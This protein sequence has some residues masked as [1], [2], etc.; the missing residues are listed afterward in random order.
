[1][2]TGSDINVFFTRVYAVASKTIHSKIGEFGAHIGYQFNNWT[3]YPLYGPMAA[4]DWKPI[5]L[6][7]AGAV[8]TKLIAEYDA[9]T[10]NVGAIVSLWK[11]HLEAMVELQAMKWVSAGIRYKVVLK[12]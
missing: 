4:V 8:S 9:R 3:R 11:D 6:Q 12:A 7:K 5:W 2:F 10:F 1:M